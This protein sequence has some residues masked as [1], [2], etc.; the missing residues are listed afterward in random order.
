MSLCLCNLYMKIGID[1]RCLMEDDIPA[2]AN[3]PI[4]F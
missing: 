3:I 4:I 2:S 1:I